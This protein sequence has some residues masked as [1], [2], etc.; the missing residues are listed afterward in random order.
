MK[1]ATWNVNSINVRLPHVLQW[2]DHAQPDVLALQ[3][4]KAVDEKFPRQAFLDAGYHVAFSGQKTYNG[5]ALLSRSPITEV[6]TDMPDWADPQRRVLAATINDVRVVNLYVPNGASVDSDKYQYKLTW[7]EQMRLFLQQQ[8]QQYER[9]VVMG[10]FNI[11]PAD[12]DVHD[13]AEWRGCV[14]VSDAERRA[15][16]AILAHGLVDVYRQFEQPEKQFSWWDYRAASFRRN[17]GLRIDLILASTALAQQCIQA[18]IDKQ[19]RAWEQPS[20]HTPVI[21]EFN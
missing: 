21:A 1:C 11:A 5:V 4:T 12:D 16:R 9:M 2:L 13:P 14:L 8:L 17:R 3:E 20:D 19:P 6:I 10:D 15:L 18:S 7:L